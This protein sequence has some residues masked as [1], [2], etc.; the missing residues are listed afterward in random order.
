MKKIIFILLASLLLASCQ[1]TADDVRK[2]KVGIST[3]DLKYV[4]GEPH[5]IR[6]QNGLEEWFYTYQSEGFFS[7]RSGLNVEI[8]NDK[9][10][11]FESY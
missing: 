6:V 11:N 8:K 4:M 3:N 5:T 1:K 2:V 7:K 9:V 10:T